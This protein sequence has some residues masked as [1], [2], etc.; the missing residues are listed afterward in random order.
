MKLGFRALCLFCLPIAL[1]VALAIQS[2]AVEADIEKGAELYKK[3]TSCHGKKPAF[4][5]KPVEYLN[6]K[7]IYYRDGEF[8]AAKVKAMKKSFSGMSD[9]NVTDLAVYVNGL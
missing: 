5:G 3:C 9:L 2:Q 7:M 6:S 4:A 1:V 8:S